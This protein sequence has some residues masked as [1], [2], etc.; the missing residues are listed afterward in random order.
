MELGQRLRQARLE[1]GLSQRQLC[2]DEITRNMLSQIEN[3]AA[4][5]SMGT[6]QYL[7]QRLGKTVSFFLEEE[8]VTSPN[9]AVMSRARQLFEAGDYLKTAEELASY[10][11]PDETFDRE[12]YLLEALNAMAL[13]ETALAQG[14][15]LYAAQLLESAAEAGKKTAYYSPELERQRLVLMGRTGTKRAAQLASQLPAEDES[16]LLRAKAALE[17]KDFERSAAYL[18]AAEDKTSARWNRLR[19]ECYFARKQYAPAAEC[20]RV[21]EAEYPRTS[22]SRLEEC[23]RELGDYKMAYEYACKGR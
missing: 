10:Q 15:Q 18:E 9:Q 4:K 19:G 17:S 21:A 11:A 22:I 3:G 16:L 13:A 1:A 12:K 14:K 2:G 7:A 20:F 8:T 6:L 23:Y 5:P